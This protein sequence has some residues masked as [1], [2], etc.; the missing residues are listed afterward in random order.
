MFPAEVERGSP[1]PSCFSSHTKNKYLSVVCLCHSFI[2]LMVVSLSKMPCSAE[3][4]SMA[5]KCKKAM[6]YLTENVGY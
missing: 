5:P 6:I 2:L 3:V 4:L 1:L